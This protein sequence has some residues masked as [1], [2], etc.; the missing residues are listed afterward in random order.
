MKK[1]K[2]QIGQ[3]LT[4]GPE[5]VVDTDEFKAA[6]DARVNAILSEAKDPDAG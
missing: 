2:L 1:L 4:Q 5:H 6:V 3:L